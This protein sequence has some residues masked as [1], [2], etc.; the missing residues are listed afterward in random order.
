MPENYTNFLKKKQIIFN[1]SGF[2]PKCKLNKYLFPFQKDIVLWALKKGRACLFED[3]GLGKTLQQLEWAKQV[4]LHTEKPVLILAP[5]AV[6][7][8]TIMEGKKFGI[9]V[10]NC[11]EQSDVKNGINITNYEKLHKFDCSVFSGVVLDESSILKSLSGMRRNQ[12]IEQFKR[13]PYKLAC[14]ATPSPNDYMELGNHSEFLGVMTYSEMLSMFFINDSADTGQWRLKKHAEETKFWEWVCSWAIM[15]SN[16]QDIGYEQEGFDLPKIVYTEHKLPAKAQKGFFVTEAKT[17]EERRDVRRETI[18]E[19]CRYTANLINT[20]EDQ[21][22]IWCGLNKEG[23]LLTKLIERAEEVSGATQ[24]EEKER[25]MLGFSTKDVH[26]IVTKP[27]IAGFGMNWQNCNKMVF[28]GLSD[29]W[30]QL[31]QATRRVWRFGQTKQVECHIVI[32]EREGAVLKN[33]KRK[34][35]LAQNMIKNMVRHTRDFVQ[36][37]LKEVIKKEEKTKTNLILPKWM[38]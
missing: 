12:I 11:S 16:P 7:Q 17:M 33:I 30:E 13:T 35:K 36:R 14:S 34:E 27:K 26:R 22:V 5:L 18:D 31:Y 29:S 21:W 15:L 28:V 23:E 38:N 9:T 3:C 19:R 24:S 37:E 20:T 2:V 25:I 6:S 8:Q 32:D 1:S 4:H 10:I